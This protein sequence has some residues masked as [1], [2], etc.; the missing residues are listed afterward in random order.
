MSPASAWAVS[1]FRRRPARS[2][3]SASWRPF[4][5]WRGRRQR[6]PPHMG[7]APVNGFGLH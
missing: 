1:S 5:V 2:T 4:S 3:A 7:S 6:K